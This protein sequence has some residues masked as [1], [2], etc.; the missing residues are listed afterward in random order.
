MHGGWQTGVAVPGDLARL[1]ADVEKHARDVGIDAGVATSVALAVHELVVNS[2][3]HAYGWDAS[4][5]DVSLWA[6]SDH[7]TVRVHDLGR[8]V[9]QRETPGRGLGLRLVH[10]VAESVSISTD[11]SGSTVE[12][13]VPCGPAAAP[14]ATA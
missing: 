11:E 8:W 13:R 6:D 1:R 2:M 7:L 5:V 3:E 10:A 12:L 14:S 4:L 9:P